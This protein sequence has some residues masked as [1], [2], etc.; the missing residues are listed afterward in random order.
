MYQFFW[1]ILHFNMR[2]PDCLLKDFE[3]LDF[4]RGCIELR[5]IVLE[6]QNVV[7]CLLGLCVDSCGLVIGPLEVQEDALLVAD[8]LKQFLLPCRDGWRD[9]Q[10][11]LHL[12]VW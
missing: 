11:M 4:I 1:S 8:I 2:I 3:G 5:M 9:V 6:G 7:Q 10:D 12:G